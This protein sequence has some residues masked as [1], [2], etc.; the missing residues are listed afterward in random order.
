YFMEV[1]LDTSFV[2][3]CIKKRI[4]FLDN[5]E[6][7][8]FK[9]L[10]PKEVFQEIKDLKLNSDIATRTAVGVAL[11]ILKKRKVKGVT[12]GNRSVDE[13]LIEFGKKGAY[14]ATLDSAIKR[15]VPNKVIISES[16]NGLAIERS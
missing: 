11:E 12:I 14:I 15:S 10:L 1:L 9:V 16:S 3:S 13:G 7:M 6:E 5:L 4:D 2:I 8:G